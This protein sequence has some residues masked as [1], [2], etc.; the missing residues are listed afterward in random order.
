[1]KRAILLIAV[2]LMLAAAAPSSFAAGTDT[3][4][5]NNAAADALVTGSTTN[6]DAGSLVTAIGA[7]AANSQ[8][9]A[10]LDEKSINP[11]SVA[12]LNVANGGAVTVFVE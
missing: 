11:S 4:T 8:L 3:S 1:M 9:K 6:A 7:I 5:N 12:A 2:A 10:K